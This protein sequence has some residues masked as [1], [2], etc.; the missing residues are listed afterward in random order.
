MAAQTGSREQNKAETRLAI[1]LA[2]VELFEE[3]GYDATTVDDIAR[4]ADVAPRTFFRYFPNKELTLFSEDISGRLAT[5]VTE[6]PAGL[7]P[8]AALR[9]AVTEL[10]DYEAT[11]LDRRRQA[12]RRKFSER[13]VIERHL[14]HLYD[15]LGT[16]LRAAF[17]ARLGVDPAE[18]LRPD[19][20]VALYLGL[21]RE[22]AKEQVPVP[23]LIERWFTAANA[24]TP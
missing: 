20:L 12:L 10:M 2:A 23:E 4:R 17:A 13:P 19:V 7:D 24:L 14:A 16:R 15:S 9:W 1:Q 6:A 11:P 3:K 5:L 22:F 18:D 21:A 8:M